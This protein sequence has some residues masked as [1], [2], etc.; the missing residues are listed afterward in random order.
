ML[1]KSKKVEVIEGWGSIKNNTTVNV[2][3][4]DGTSQEI[5]SDYIVLATGSK[6]RSIPSIEVDEEF[7]ITSD[8]ALNWEQPPKKVCIIGAGAIGCEFASLLNDLESEVTVVELDKEILPGLDR[9]HLASLENN[10]L[11]RY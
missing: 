9:E 4:A 1:L 10:L 7:V 8:T 2:S 5:E 3:K 6:P 11:K